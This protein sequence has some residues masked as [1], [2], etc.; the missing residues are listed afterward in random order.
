MQFLETYDLDH[1]KPKF[2]GKIMSELLK[3]YIHL[4]E[5]DFKPDYIGKL[6]GSDFKKIVHGFYENLDLYGLD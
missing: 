4:Q 3:D 1:L 2:V 5:P 6:T